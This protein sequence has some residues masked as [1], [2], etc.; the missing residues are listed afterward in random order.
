VSGQ[1]RKKIIEI[2]SNHPE[3]LMRQQLF[4]LVYADDPDGGPNNEN[5]ISVH[6]RFINKE[7]E[8]Q[9][10]KIEKYKLVNTHATAKREPA[11]HPYAR[12]MEGVESRIT[13]RIHR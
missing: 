7:I 10:W 6:I 3:G 5:V 9:G 13:P 4:Q 2:I 11:R 8:P 12:A 1:V